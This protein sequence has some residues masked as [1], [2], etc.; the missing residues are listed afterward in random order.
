VH[1]VNGRKKKKNNKA[2]RGEGSI[3]KKRRVFEVGKEIEGELSKRKAAREK[4]QSWPK[5]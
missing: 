3:P 2:K 4:L 1:I 5:P